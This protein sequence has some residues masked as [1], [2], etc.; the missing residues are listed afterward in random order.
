[1]FLIRAMIMLICTGLRPRNESTWNS[2]GYLFVLCSQTKLLDRW[3]RYGIIV[4]QKKTKQKIA[5]HY[6]SV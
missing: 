2:V 4:W 5:E 3:K 1:M 6:F